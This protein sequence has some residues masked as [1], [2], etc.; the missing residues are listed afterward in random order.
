MDIVGSLGSR[1]VSD[2]YNEDGVTVV[3]EMAS[4]SDLPCFS[5]HFFAPSTLASNIVYSSVVINY[6]L[7]PAKKLF[8]LILNQYMYCRS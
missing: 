2:N 8:C 1:L 6:K 7:S 3:M 4:D 5:L